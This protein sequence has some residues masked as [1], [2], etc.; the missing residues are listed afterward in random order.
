[1]NLTASDIIK[2]AF[3][4]IGVL[5]KGETPTAD[6]MND[7]LQTLN[8]MIGKWGA[9]GLMCLVDVSD[10]L[11]LTANKISYQIGLS[12]TAPDFQTLKPNKINFAVIRDGFNYDQPCGIMTTE[13][14]GALDDKLVSRARPTDLYY[15]PGSTQQANQKGTIYLYPGPDSSTT[16]QL[17][18]SSQKTLT[19]FSNLTDAFTFLPAYYEAFKYN[20]AERF[21]REYHEH[22]KPI[23]QDIIDGAMDSMR[24]VETMN[25]KP[26]IASMDIPGRKWAYNV[27]TDDWG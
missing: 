16:Y 19:E 20:L 18:L 3:R 15:D 24:V 21:Y 4:I 26:I 22:N 11:N 13:Q 23:P 8:M 17:L 2:S 7:G 10:T 12:C 27:Y 6:E 25:A 1:M 14:Y 5:A 9:R